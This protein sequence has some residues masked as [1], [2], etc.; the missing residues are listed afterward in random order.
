MKKLIEYDKSN[1]D[2]II[3]QVDDK[4]NALQNE[5]F[6]EMP[7][8]MVR[9]II[10]DYKWLESADEDDIL[11]LKTENIIEVIL[12]IE[13]NAESRIKE[14]V[15]V[16]KIINWV[17]I[18]YSDWEIKTW[19]TKVEEAKKIISGW[20]SPLLNMYKPKGITL[21]DYAKKIL[22]KA[23]EKSVITAQIEQEK[24]NAINNLYK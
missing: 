11:L 24:N 22:Q 23:Q 2:F 14:E 13:K 18:Y 1:N 19:S 9:P 20:E 5:T 15:F 21:L 4:Y 3:R 8:D 17:K 7:Q 16:K 10:K 12:E 6:E